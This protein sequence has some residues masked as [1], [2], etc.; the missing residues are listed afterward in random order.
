MSPT[1][2]SVCSEPQPSLL[3]GGRSCHRLGDPLALPAARS[4]VQV[5]FQPSQWRG[6]LVSS[7]LSVHGAMKPQVARDRGVHSPASTLL[8]VLPASAAPCARLFPSVLES[9][10][11]PRLPGPTSL[12][13]LL[14]LG[15]SACEFGGQSASPEGR[16]TAL[17][18]Q[19]SVS[20]E[21]WHHPLL[22]VA[23]APHSQLWGPLP[24][25]VL[26]PFALL[27]SSL[28]ACCILIPLPRDVHP[29]RAWTL[30]FVIFLKLG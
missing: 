10:H 19:K 3:A 7:Q 15:D 9:P 4:S 30:P 22:P 27:C 12:A 20:G 2:P 23:A 5:S 17:L 16:G 26:W 1:L 21:A 14:G 28:T 29:Q 11:S 6:S 18:A 25:L 13:T 8:R 24:P